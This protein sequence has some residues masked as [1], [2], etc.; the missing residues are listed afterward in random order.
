MAM[1]NWNWVSPEMAANSVK[2]INDAANTNYE[3]NQKRQANAIAASHIDASGNLTGG[4]YKAAADAGLGF[5]KIKQAADYYTG[6]NA[7]NAQNVM[8][9]NVI[10]QG[11]GDPG[12]TRSKTGLAAIYE[13]PP[14]A[15]PTTVQQPTASP[16]TGPLSA[17]HSRLDDVAEW[18]KSIFSPGGDKNTDDSSKETVPSADN[19]PDLV[20]PDDGSTSKN[21]AYITPDNELFKSKARMPWMD[22]SGHYTDRTPPQPADTTGFT[23]PDMVQSGSGYKASESGVSGQGQD[24][25][26]A[27]VVADP[28]SLTDPQY[29]SPSQPETAPA[30]SEFVTQAPVAQTAQTPP[31]VPPAAQTTAAQAPSQP[32]PAGN[33]QPWFYNSYDAW[34]SPFKQIGEDQSAGS[35]SVPDADKQLMQWEVKDDGSNL[36]RQ[37]SSAL[38]Q[39]LNSVGFSTSGSDKTTS[40]TATRYLQ[41]VYTNTL[42][43]NTPAGVNPYVILKDPKNPGAGLSE[44]GEQMVK[45]TQQGKI[46]EG[47]AREAVLQAKAALSGIADKY[48]VQNAQEK[49]LQVG[50]GRMLYDKSKR[51]NVAILKMVKADVPALQKQVKAA[52]DIVSLQML[53]PQVAKASGQSMGGVQPTEFNIAEVYKGAFPELDKVTAARIAV[54]TAQGIRT[55]NFSKATA[56]LDG[57]VKSYDTDTLKARLSNMLDLANKN[58]DI[59]LKTYTYGGSKVREI[60][61]DKD[62]GAVTP[63]TEP[64]AAP[65]AAPVATPK[66]S[67]YNTAGSNSFTGTKTTQNGGNVHYW[68]T[69]RDVDGNATEATDPIGGKYTIKDAGTGVHLIPVQA[70]TPTPARGTKHGSRPKPVARPHKDGD[71]WSDAHYTYKMIK[72][73]QYRKAR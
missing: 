68:V 55:G 30:D 12:T 1:I 67:W 9:Y 32:Q 70:P 71:T 29:L 3:E 41:S 26:G 69:A 15:Q 13:Q 66:G 33:D 73:Q 24:T 49:E 7:Q 39:Y 27:T 42:L 72:G 11:G 38:N 5:D 43:S 35:P 61:N 16:H 36:Y 20:M 10:K 23:T 34:K 4:Y 58:A 63:A 31:S 18:L 48:G 8:N 54:A 53:L 44:Y 25:T 52:G 6:Q 65:A 22:A 17:N 21:Y 56:A 46:A 2:T 28:N 19:K 50:D 47:K 60:Q 64:A 45:N 62:S 14:V 59:G 37:Y 57:L 51:E 40:D